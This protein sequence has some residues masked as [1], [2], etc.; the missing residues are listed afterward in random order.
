MSG[1]IEQNKPKTKKDNQKSVFT[2]YIETEEPKL[3]VY[4]N[5]GEMERIHEWVMQY[6][7]IETGCG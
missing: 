6:P 7:D 4:I 2:V 1:I 5:A 3:K